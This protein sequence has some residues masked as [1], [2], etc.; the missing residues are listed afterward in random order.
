MELLVSLGLLLIIAKLLEGVATRL[1]QSSL[2]AYVAA[3]IILGPVLGWVEAT[4]E[5]RLFFGIG[6]VFLFFLIGVEEMDVS[7]LAATIRGRFFLAG[8]VAFLVSFGF[9]FAVTLGVLEQPMVNSIAISG[10]LALSSLGVVAKVLSDLGR[11]REPL[12]LEIFTTVVI[13][14]IIGLLVVSFSIRTI[15]EEG[16]F[17]PWTVPILLAEIAGFAVVAWLLASKVF[18]PLVAR[19]RRIIDAPQLA[20]GL[21][22]GGLLLTVGL[23]D[24]IGIHGSLGALLLGVSLS[25]LPHRLRTEILPGVRGLAYGLFIPLFF[26]SAGIYLDSSFRFLPAWWIVAVVLAA[27]L[28]KFMGTL[29]G[30]IVARL[31][32]PLAIASGMMGKGVVEIALLVV[33][34]NME[35]ISQELFSLLVLIMICFL[36][37]VPPVLGRAIGRAEHVAAE[38]TP[39]LPKFVVP[40]FARYALDN[41]T[42]QDIMDR[43]RQFPNSGITVQKFVDLW[44]SSDQTDYVVTKDP[45]TLAGV[46]YLKDIRHINKERWGT[47][48]IDELLELEPIVASPDELL[49]DVTRRMADGNMTIV[50]V[51]DKATGELLGSITS[52]DIMASVIGSGKHGGAK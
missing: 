26:A 33:M 23:V 48:T 24:K 12:G 21:I 43:G 39:K 31:T 25:G 13:L 3:G 52:S 35:A 37:I 1:R 9:A 49:D 18:P 11:L 8:T 15:A 50:P 7:G 22:T 29:V 30:V 42:V 19:L 17:T 44:A 10:I 20:M 4:E 16:S 27:V 14:E 38:G 45:K 36:L 6:V 41:K 51:V 46:L 28:G 40:S 34:L 47:I 5:L 2:V 32:Q